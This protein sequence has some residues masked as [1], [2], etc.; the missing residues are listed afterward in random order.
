MVAFHRDRPAVRVMQLRNTPL[1]AP[2]AFVD[3]STL[4]RFSI[5]RSLLPHLPRFAT[6]PARRNLLLG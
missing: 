1:V 3:H 2:A 4:L 6:I 5:I